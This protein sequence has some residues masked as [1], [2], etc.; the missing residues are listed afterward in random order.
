[1]SEENKKVSEEV[2]I[3]LKSRRNAIAYLQGDVVNKQVSLQVSNREYNIYLQEHLKLAGCNLEK[4]W[5]VD[6]KTGEINEKK[7]EVKITPAKEEE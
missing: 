2:L 7:E 5:L 4:Q 6:E 3:Q 1:M